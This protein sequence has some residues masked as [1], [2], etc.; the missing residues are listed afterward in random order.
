[1][2]YP[3]VSEV[4]E[5]NRKMNEAKLRQR[6]QLSLPRI[7]NISLQFLAVHKL[8]VMMEH[9]H[10]PIALEMGVGIRISRSFSTA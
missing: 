9:T 4:E 8:W 5:L 7:Y 1:M 6:T 2:T 10:N 3:H